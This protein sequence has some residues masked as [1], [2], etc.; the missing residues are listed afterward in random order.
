MNVVNILQSATKLIAQPWDRV[1]VALDFD[2][3]PEMT[4]TIML[5]RADICSPNV[6][7]II[8]VV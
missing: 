7:K 6:L 3:E 5:L 8:D 4:E 1:T 2:S